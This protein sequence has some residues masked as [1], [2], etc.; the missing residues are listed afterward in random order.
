MTPIAI[1]V[2]VALGL[3]LLFMLADWL[4]M[5]VL[6]R[7]TVTRL[8]KQTGRDPRMREHSKYGIVSADGERLRVETR[9]GRV[10][11]P[12][13]E[14]AEVH[15][16]KRDIFTADLICLAFIGEDTQSPIEIH[17]DMAGYYDLLQTLPDRLPGL[18]STWF[19]EV[20]FPAFEMNHQT[21]W[22]RSQA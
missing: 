12:W 15:A 1:A 22:T 14:V 8:L 20:A 7:R 3:F 9:D 21:I 16:F 13:K 5:P 4:L 18:T 19:L 17:E 2:A 10:E 11:L 6:A